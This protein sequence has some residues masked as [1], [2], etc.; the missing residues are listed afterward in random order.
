MSAPTQAAPFSTATGSDVRV[1]FCPS[2]TGT[3]HVGLIRTALFN[4]AYARHTGGT[5]VFRVEDTDAARDSEESYLQLLDALRWLHLD[6]DE[7]VETGGPHEPY[8]QSQRGEIYLGVIERL[9]ASGHLYESFV[10][11][12]E[13]EARNVA[14]GRDPKQGYDNFE[15]SLTVEER[16]AFKAEG[17]SPALR[18]KVPDTDLSFDDLVRGEITFPAGSFSDFVVVR[19]NGAPLYTFVNPV[20][21]AL[22]GITHVL[23]GEDLLSSTPRQIALYSALIEIGLTTFVPRFGHLPYVMGEGNKKLS[24]RDPES[25]LFHHRDR[26]FI[27]EGL[28]NYLSL[29][30]WSL[31][32]DRDVFSSD[33]MVAAFEVT[34]VNPNPARFDL[35]KAESINGDHIRLLAVDDLA[36][37]LEPHLADVVKT[38]DDRA[39][40]RL[41]TPL[42]QE[43]MQLLGEAPAL[44]GFLFVPDDTIEYDGDAMPGDEAPQVLET[45]IASLGPVK[46]W[47]HDEIEAA[48]RTSLIEELGLKP[49]LAFGA[50]RT[51]LSGKR[52]SP[53]LFE[54]MELLGKES[55]IARLERLRA[56]L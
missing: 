55:T 19:P 8:R 14:A 38:E 31:T 23:R 50:L 44:L 46:V 33:E 30:G 47:E 32:H 40:L 7:G 5:L 17:R 6:W 11:P 52:I 26:G 42:V 4:W 27:P 12:E 25:N 37:R 39:L 3:P 51:A 16:D 36:A 1:R 24:K 29:L 56:R 45:A 2:P 13:M 20:D 54:S 22:M 35:K 43:R 34:D 18:L 15:R 28:V 53:P 21:D 49:R 48:L 9:T 10:T 41:A